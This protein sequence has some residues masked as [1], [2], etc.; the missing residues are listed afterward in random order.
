[1]ASSAAHLCVTTFK[2][3]AMTNAQNADT[4]E[5]FL[6]TDIH[7]LLAARRSRLREERTQ[8]RSARQRDSSAEGT[9]VLRGGRDPPA[10]VRPQSKPAPLHGLLSVR[11][12]T[13]VKPPKRVTQRPR[14]VAGFQR[15]CSLRRGRLHTT[16]TTGPER[17]G[18]GERG[19]EPALAGAVVPE[20]L[21]RAIEQGSA[22]LSDKRVSEALKRFSE[23]L[24]LVRAHAGATPQVLSEVLARRSAAQLAAGDPERAL[25]DGLAAVQQAATSE[26]RA[27]SSVSHA[28]QRKPR[29][30]LTA[31][32]GQAL[33]ST[34]CALGALHD[35]TNALRYYTAWSKREAAGCVLSA[36][37]KPRPAVHS[38]SRS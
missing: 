8:T 10:G 20:L 17:S 28:A 7:S 37:A 29:R 11:V 33:L 26:V 34:A 16:A 22:A 23:A 36:P 14:R 13:L 4:K 15:R 27:R 18:A 6:P 21:R 25:E 24:E 3:C 31:V 35:H 19:G 30:S 12:R 2:L 9:C 1:M 38:Q 32:S 5:E